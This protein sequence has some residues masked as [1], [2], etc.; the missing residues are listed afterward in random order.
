MGGGR[1]SLPF[2]KYIVWY[3][4]FKPTR[5]PRFFSIFLWCNARE[6][7]SRVMP[8]DADSLKSRWQ[9][10][11]NLSS[12]FVEASSKT[13]LEE[14]NL[15]IQNKSEETTSPLTLQNSIIEAGCWIEMIF[16]SF[17]DNLGFLRMEEL[18]LATSCILLR[19]RPST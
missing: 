14:L 2:E 3:E 8:C 10:H 4:K 19:P 7:Y 5:L 1:F 17:V 11:L 16:W 13:K 9:C 18:D 12:N 15:T 6:C